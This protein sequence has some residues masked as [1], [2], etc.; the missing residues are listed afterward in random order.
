MKEKIKII[1]TDDQ[2]VFRKGL[3]A[4][5]EPE[6]FQIIA[7]A[8]NGLELLHLLE[9]EKIVPDLVLLD[10]DMPKMDGNE[11]LAAIR[12]I[13]KDIKVIIMST[14]NEGCLVND[15]IA[16][17]ANSYLTKNTD[18]KIIVETIKRVHYL[19]NYSNISEKTKSIF[20]DGEIQIIP[21]VLAG[22]TSKEIAEI[23]NLAPKTVEGYRERLYEKTGTSNTSEFS[24]YC[25]RYGLEFL[26]RSFNLN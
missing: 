8:V 14:F 18:I 11:T 25:A 21:F 12:K 3:R 24:S 22:K 7:E 2:L 20:T 4:L 6:N 19:E 16:K 15:F 1:I 9:I 23:L 5:L 13:N 26:G 17:G 10:L